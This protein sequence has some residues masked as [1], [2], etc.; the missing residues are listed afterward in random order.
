MQCRDAMQ[1]RDAMQCRNAMQGCNAVQGCERQGGGRGGGR[2]LGSPRRT[3]RKLWH[4]TDALSDSCWHR[5]AYMSWKNT[6]FRAFS[7]TRVITWWVR[8]HR[9]KPKK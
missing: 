1:Y 7:N 2:G 8:K 9:A 4:H 5:L 6:S 3:F